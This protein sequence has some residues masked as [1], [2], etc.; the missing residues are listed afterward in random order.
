MRIWLQSL[1]GLA[2]VLAATAAPPAPAPSAVAVVYNSSQPESEKLARYYIQARGIPEEN[3]IGL[4]VPAKQDISRA[5]FEMT[6]LEPLR[7]TFDKRGWWQRQRDSKGT[8]L[9][10]TNKIRVLT[11]MRG[12]PLRIKAEPKPAA[13]PEK[14]NPKAA[15]EN[16]ITSRDD[17]SV[18]SELSLF[19]VEGLPT[20]GVLDNKFFKSTQPIATAP[21]PFVVLTARI[22]GPTA[23]VCQRMIDDAIATEPGGLWGMAYV[24]IANKY[25]DGDKW[26][27]KIVETNLKQGIPT[28]V[29]RF[30]D[31]LPTNYPMTSA[32]LYYGWY[33]LNVSG[34]FLNS[35]F[36]FR[37]GAIAMHLHSFSA[38]QLSDPTRN[39][40]AA[41]LLKGAAATIGNVHEPYLHLTH[42]FDILHEKLLA[43]HTFVEAAWMSIPVA[44]WQAVV[45]GDPLYRPFARFDGRGPANPADNEWRAIRMAALKWGDKPAEMV[46][47]LEE[48]AKRLESG[49]LSEEVG[50][51][52]LAANRSTDAVLW[53][54]QAKRRYRDAPDKMRQDFNLIAIDRAAP[55]GKP[56]AVQALREARIRY[57]QVPESIA[58]AGWLDILDPP[59]PPPADPTKPAAPARPKS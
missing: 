55:D 3:L 21:L 19:G 34:P 50:L 49:V 38:E 54:N 8:L 28:V 52:H 1:L 13:K 31:T 23:A 37:R 35:K 27:A 46:V 18:D 24:D 5:E 42:Y 36:Q 10:F 11:L 59:P 4:K 20:L 32:A 9:P 7:A 29:D 14:P 51:R 6:L 53:F 12:I 30:N 17:A 41:L 47:Q 33:D 16:P 45:L 22:D 48:A 57:G 44:S 2:L 56:R 25:P 26:L 43:G 15:P 58:F 39:W 40:S